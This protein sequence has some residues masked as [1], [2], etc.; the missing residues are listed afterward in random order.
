MRPMITL[1]IL[2]LSCSTLSAFAEDRA[3]FLLRKPVNPENL[4]QTYIPVGSDCSLESID[5]YWLMG[6][7]QP[8][9]PNSILRC[10]LLK[11]LKG[12]PVNSSN[13]A[14]CPSQLPPGAA[15]FQKFIT[16]DEIALTGQNKPLVIRSVKSASTGQCAVAAFVDLGDKVVQVKQVNT[17]GQLLS[18]SLTGATVKFTG[19]Q[20]IGMDGNVAADWKCT[21]AQCVNQ[22]SADF[23]CRL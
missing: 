3:L 15:C 14:A 4:V 13:R 16:A 7:T 9:S 5:F 2:L 8:K 11:R 6:G 10:N 23:G 19:V 22:V 18:Q 17:N 21:S 1:T 12:A 20:I